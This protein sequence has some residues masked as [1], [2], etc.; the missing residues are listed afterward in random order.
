MDKKRLEKRASRLYSLW[1]VL[2]ALFSIG[3]SIYMAYQEVFNGIDLRVLPTTFH[4]VL[5]AILAVVFVPMLVFVRKW[6]KASDSD[7]LYAKATK[8]FWA[9]VISITGT[10]ILNILGFLIPGLFS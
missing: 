6:A 4:F 7:K 5:C 2:I 9:F 8:W 10:L 3:V 1:R